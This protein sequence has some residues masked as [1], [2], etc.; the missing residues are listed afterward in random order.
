MSSISNNK[1]PVQAQGKSSVNQGN[2]LIGVSESESE[3]KNKFLQSLGRLAF[4]VSPN[5]STIKPSVEITEE[6]QNNKYSSK[7]FFVLPED[8]AEKN[9]YRGGLEQLPEQPFNMEVA[10]RID[11][12]RALVGKP[13]KQNLN[14]VSRYLL[15][16]I[17]PM[18][19]G[20]DGGIEQARSI[21]Y[22]TVSDVD[23]FPFMTLDALV[24]EAV[25]MKL[26]KFVEVYCALDKG[27]A[28]QLVEKIMPAKQREIVV[29]V[30]LENRKVSKNA[31]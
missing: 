19:L 7:F 15:N 10:R 30:P 31:D 5:T 2:P 20:I 28:A 9:R 4:P 16:E 29:P 8:F 17:V 25:K 11:Q 24:R 14:A 23:P 1:N 6:E 13:V 18:L 12:Y 3:A 26:A 22:N 27:A 21:V